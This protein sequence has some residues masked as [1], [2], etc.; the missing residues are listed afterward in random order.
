M[1]A[2]TKKDLVGLFTMVSPHERDA[3]VRVQDAITKK[4]ADLNIA[5]AAKKVAPAS[6]DQAGSELSFDGVDISI[7]GAEPSV[8]QV[9]ENVAVVHISSGQV[10][11]HVEPSETRGAL[12]SIYDNVNDPQPTD[13]TWDI[14]EMGPSGSG[15]TVMAS[16]TDG[17]WYVNLSMSVLEAINSYEGSPRGTIPASFPAGSDTPQAAAKAALQA[18]ERQSPTELAPFLAK[19]EAAAMYLY[20]HL[21]NRVNTS[22]W[23]FSFGNIDFTEGPHEGNR[24][25]AYVNQINVNAG[26][27]H[28]TMTDKCLRDNSSSADNNCLN[29]SAYQ[30][31]GYS[32]GTI[33][34]MS[35]ALSHEGKFALTTVSEDGKWKLSVLDTVADHLASAANSFT[36][37]QAFALMQLA[38]ADDPAGTLTLNKS[39]ELAYNNAGYAVTTLKVD[40]PVKLQL[41][42]DSTIGRLA[43][44]S[45]DGKTDR[46]T[47]TSYQGTNSI[48]PAG[49]YKAVAWA[50]SNFQEAFSKDGNSAKVSSALTVTE[51]I[52]PATI[53]GS[54]TSTGRSISSFGSS[55]QIEVPNDAAGALLVKVNSADSDSKIIATIGGKSYNVD[56]AEGSTTGIPVGKGSYTLTL[57][58]ENS[59]FYSSTNVDLSFEKQ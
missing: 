44:Y 59:S 56:T 35:A 47:V 55:F 14:N 40:K 54:E 43:L 33:N 19:D 49:E 29:G 46:G 28:F 24:A 41:N 31:D 37:E 1:D 30:S 27:D 12:R 53:D 23:S 48:I 21:W 52:D 10:K 26:G 18:T 3:L 16:K 58:T 17:R 22:G 32:S 50:G 13:Q 25:Q 39:Q 15:L 5:D 45:P 11:L 36:R 51:Y 2:I 20:G 42:Q 57:S 8:S 9:S 6:S 4:A 7:T 34:W 38:R